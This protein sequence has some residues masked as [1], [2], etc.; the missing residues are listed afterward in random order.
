MD[1]TAQLYAFQ[2]IPRLKGGKTVNFHLLFFTNLAQLKASLFL[3]A[4]RQIK[5]LNVSP[6]QRDNKPA[7]TDGIL[8]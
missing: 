4:N 5:G 2:S 6:V 7:R 1:K 3:P 8:A